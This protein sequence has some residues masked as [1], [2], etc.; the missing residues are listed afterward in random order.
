[1]HRRRVLLVDP[2]DAFLDGLCALMAKDPGLKV[3]GRAHSAGAAIDRARELLPDLV[4]MDVSLPDRSGFEV[5]PWLKEQRPTP[6]VLLT[7]C[8]QSRITELAAM[9]VG[10]DA[11]MS[12]TEL[13]DRLL[14]VLQEL[15]WPEDARREL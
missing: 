14:L 4:L 6:R 7:T 9:K 1:L 12:K 3:V 15:L 5:V 8:H 2:S 13:P 11:C 10:A